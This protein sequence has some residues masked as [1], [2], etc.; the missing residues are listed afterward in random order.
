MYTTHS[1]QKNITVAA[2]ANVL[3]ITLT[4]AR[5]GIAAGKFDDFAFTFAR[6]NRRRFIINKIAFI[7]YLRSKGWQDS[8]IEKEL[9]G[10]I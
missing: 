6:G 4:A 7:H 8:E 10:A 1:Q 3:G 9:K 5:E 2:M